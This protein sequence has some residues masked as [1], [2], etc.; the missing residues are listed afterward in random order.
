MP[1]AKSG[2]PKEQAGGQG[3]G[4]RK[5]RVARLERTLE[6]V[7]AAQDKRT[8]QLERLQAR[9][10]ELAARLAALR[11]PEAAASDGL[12]SGAVG[13]G[14]PAQPSTEPVRRAYCMHDKRMVAIHDPEL[15]VLRN[16]RRA[17]AGTCGDCGTH[18]VAIVGG[19]AIAMDGQGAP[20]EA[21]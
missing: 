17:V 8:A 7:A 4:R 14:T 12:A 15:V 3:P 10:A 9:A 19:P 13:E 5:K 11:A 1:K 18:V 21:S 16:G 6:K 2:V 20:V